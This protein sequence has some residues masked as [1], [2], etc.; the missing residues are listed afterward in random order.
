M[1][2]IVKRKHGFLNDLIQGLGHQAAR[3]GFGCL[4]AIF[5][6]GQMWRHL[7]LGK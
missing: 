2:P 7:I 6:L 1:L 3:F 5:K 4:C